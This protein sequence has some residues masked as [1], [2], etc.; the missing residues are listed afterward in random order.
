M[1]LYFFMSKV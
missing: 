1:L